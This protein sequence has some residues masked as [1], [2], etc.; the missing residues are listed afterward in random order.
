MQH[1]E[2]TYRAIQSFIEKPPGKLRIFEI[3]PPKPL[4]SMALGSRIPALR[5]DYKTGRLCG[6]YFLATVGKLLGKNVP[7]PR[8]TPKIVVPGPVVVPPA[9]VA[10]D[11]HAPVVAVLSIR[12]VTLISRRLPAMNLPAFSARRRLVYRA[13]SFRPPRRRIFPVYWR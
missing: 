7:L 12:T 11:A 13:L 6:R 4:H 2:A 10:N 9:P 5:E 1:H 8:Q 3:Y